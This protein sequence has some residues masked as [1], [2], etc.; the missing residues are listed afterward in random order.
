MLLACPPHRFFWFG[1]QSCGKASPMPELSNRDV[2]RSRFQYRSCCCRFQ[3]CQCNTHRLHPNSIAYIG[4]TFWWDPNQIKI[5]MVNKHIILEESLVL[6]FLP[7]EDKRGD[8]VRW[9]GCL[10]RH[11]SACSSLTVGNLPSSMHLL[12]SNELRSQGKRCR[13]VLVDLSL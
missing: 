9:L 11:P 3:H 4:V 12:V 1:L 6:A 7:P 2:P 8:M 5:L 13:T 10:L